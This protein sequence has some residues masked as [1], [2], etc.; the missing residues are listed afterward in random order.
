MNVFDFDKTIYSGDSTAAFFFWC[1]KKHPKVLIYVPKI[2]VASLSYYAFHIGSKTDFKEKM[3]SF[4]KACDG[5]KDVADFWRD[6]LKNIKK[7]YIEMHKDDDVIISA[8]PE[9]LLKPLEKELNITVIASIVDIHTGKYTGV[10]CYHAEK[11][12]R[13]REIYPDGMID[14]FYSDSY[15]DEPLAAI[16]KSAYIVD[17]ENITEWDRTHHKKNLRV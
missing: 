13:F 10:N 2:A 16:A 9:F 17:G 12:R 7:F 15:S 5:E 4:L 8:S 1:L 11:V 3:Y 6:N 14:S